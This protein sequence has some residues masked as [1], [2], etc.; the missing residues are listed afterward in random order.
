MCGRCRCTLNPEDVPRACGI[1]ASSIPVIQSERLIPSLSCPTFFLFLYFSQFTPSELASSRILLC[2]ALFS[3]AYHPSYNVSPG[4]YLPVVRKE[5]GANSEPVVHCMKWGLIPS[6]TK[7][8]EKPDHFK[9]FNARSESACEK[10]SFRRLIP[11]NR[12]LMAAEGFYEWKKDGH[13]KQPYYIHFNDHRPLVF[14]ALYDSWTNAEGEVIHTFTILTTRCS[15]ALEWLHDRMPVIFGDD[16][17][18][19]AWLSSLPSTKVVGMLQPYEGTDLAWYPVTPM[20]GKPSFNGPECIKEI[21]LKQEQ[22]AAISSF[23]SKRSLER[24]TTPESQKKSSS[25]SPD[26]EDFVKKIASTDNSESFELERKTT[27]ESSSKSPNCEDFVKEIASSDNS[28]SFELEQK[29]T[30]GSQKKSSS[31]SPNCEDFVKEIASTDNSESFNTPDRDGS[32]AF[33][34]TEAVKKCGTKRDFEQL[35]DSD[36]NMLKGVAY[37]NSPSMVDIASDKSQLPI[38]RKSGV[39]N[40]QTLLSYFGRC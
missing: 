11:N 24:K 37:H 35:D 26:C 2:D 15:S 33:E 8:T 13:K 7:K 38:K 25:K 36:G 20:M 4:T 14:A 34:I 10:A 27:P 21:Q 29:T 28:E 19:N 39:P 9:M 32:E 30:P 18:K 31:K 6:F 22:R 23:F 12:C 3:S 1:N 17:S 40:Q 16:D 5:R